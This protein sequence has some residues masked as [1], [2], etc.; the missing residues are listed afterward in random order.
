MSR[1]IGERSR[2]G[3]FRNSTVTPA[4]ALEGG[5]SRWQ[6]GWEPPQRVART[7]EV[8]MRLIMTLMVRDEADVIGAMIEHHRAQGIDH[9]LVTD[10]ASIDGTTEIL[11]EYAAEGFVTLWHDPEHRKQQWS[12]VTRMARFAATDLGADWVINA[13]ADEFFV[14]TDPSRTVREVIESAAGEVTHLVVPVVNLTGAPA[15]DGSGFDR[16]VYRD[17]RT[18]EELHA[19]GIPFHPTADAIHRANPEIEISQGNHFVSAPGWSE[20][21]A[22]D[23]LEVL[24][25]PWRSWR[26]YEHKVR[27]AGSAYEANPDLAPSPRHHGMQDYRRLQGGRLEETYVSKHPRP[28]EVEEMLRSGSLRHEDRLRALT[29]LTKRGVRADV[30]YAASEQQ[31]LSEVGR[32]FAALEAENESRMLDLRREQSDERAIWLGARERLL[33]ETARNSELEACNAQLEARN[34]ELSEQLARVNARLAVRV[35]DRIHRLFTG[36]R[37]AEDTGVRSD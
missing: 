7:P 30:A 18:D 36:S 15:K 13:D 9:I 35:A 34:A 32:A 27:A 10:N 24:H 22:T 1:A 23:D 11:E 14:P 17:Q 25:L 20:G 12:V 4:V 37:H 6:D 28:G 2:F 29:E 33:L 19:A 5:G 21:A 16:L 8:Q 3:I 26:Q 31:R